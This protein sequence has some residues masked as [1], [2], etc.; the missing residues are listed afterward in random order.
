MDIR[1]PIHSDHARTLDSASLRR[2]LLVES[3][4]VPGQLALT[5]SQID[6]IV[7]GGAMPLREEVGFTADLAKSFAVGAFLE[8]RELGAI[9]VGG[10]GSVVV[11]GSTYALGHREA[12]YVG[13][14]ARDVRFRSDD[15]R[16]PAKFY[17]NSAPAHRACPTRKLTLA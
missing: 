17:L 13:M 8:R 3:V 10:A 1:Q 15:A 5:Y 9:N 12:L 11:D 2:E 14:G 6:R 7:V 4:F 16:N